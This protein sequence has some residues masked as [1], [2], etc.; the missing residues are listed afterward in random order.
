MPFNVMYLIKDKGKG[1]DGNRA[2]S[3][4]NQEIVPASTQFYKFSFLNTEVC[5]VKI[6]GGKS[7]PI[8]ADQGVQTDDNDAPIF[9]FVIV[10]S[11]INYKWFGKY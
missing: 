3:T 6:N 1:Y 2:V 11:G 8:D 4:A 9:S 10:E 7:I 5:T